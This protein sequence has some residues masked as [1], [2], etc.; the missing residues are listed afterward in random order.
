MIET[1]PPI[2]GT[3]AQRRPFAISLG[4]RL[5]GEV[6]S[7]IFEKFKSEEALDHVPEYIL[8]NWIGCG[9][10]KCRNH[11]SKPHALGRCPVCQKWSIK[12]THQGEMEIYRCL[13]NECGWELELPC[14]K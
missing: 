10:E 8:L 12:L 11:F 4:C 3:M 13:N 7:R 5:C 2:R 6:G 14:L 9:N 1:A